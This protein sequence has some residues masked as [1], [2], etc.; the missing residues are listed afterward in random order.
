MHLGHIDTVHI[1]DKVLYQD[2]E[3]NSSLQGAP[4]YLGKSCQ[5]PTWLKGRR[6]NFSGDSFTL[7][8]FVGFVL[9]HLPRAFKPATWNTGEQDSK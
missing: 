7:W 5:T 1:T 4:P 6:A 8:I 9:E 2:F 3:L